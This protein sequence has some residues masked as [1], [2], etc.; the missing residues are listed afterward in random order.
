MRDQ[1]ESQ[2]RALH[3]EIWNLL[4]WHVNGTLNERQAS[5]VEKH[6]AECAEC[7]S[8]YTSQ[9]ALQQHLREDDSVVQTP[10]ASLRK[11]MARIEQDDQAPADREPGQSRRTR[12]LVA[13]VVVQAVGLITLSGVM[14]WKLQSV[15]SEP[16]YATVSSAA[17]P[18][19]NAV[20]AR[21]V[22]SPSMATGDLVSLLRSMEA[23]IVAGP[24]E[25][26]VYTLAF[27]ETMSEQDVAN[28]VAGLR[29]RADVRFAEVAVADP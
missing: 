17:V 20:A 1:F 12:W 10:H 11:L 27:P 21:V 13:A 15:R 29:A 14:T 22:F 3:R 6:L 7:R 5:R 18:T 9:Q 26:G 2:H 4:P 25:A 23:Q 16:R 8:E 19:S 24:S 28:A